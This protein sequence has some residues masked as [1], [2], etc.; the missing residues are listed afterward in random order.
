MV[1]AIVDMASSGCYQSADFVEHLMRMVRVPATAASSTSAPCG[2]A[3]QLR[4]C[5]RCE[6]PGWHSFLSDLLY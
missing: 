6:M 4:G 3:E 5:C 2:L 1:R